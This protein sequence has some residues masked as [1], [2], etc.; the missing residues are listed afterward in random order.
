[1][2]INEEITRANTPLAVTFSDGEVFVLDEINAIDASIVGSQNK[3]NGLILDCMN[4]AEKRRSLFKKGTR[5]D[6]D[7]R[8]IVSIRPIITVSGGETESTLH[9]QGNGVGPRI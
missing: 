3:W 8:E 6:F 4:V 2:E 9:R 1:M 7:Q 5:I